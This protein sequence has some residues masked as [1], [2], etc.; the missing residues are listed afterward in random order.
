MGPGIFCLALGGGLLFF[1][2]R[3]PANR[4]RT[5][6]WLSL[7]ALRAGKAGGEIL[8]TPSQVLITETGAE[9]RVSYSIFEA[10]SETDHCFLLFFGNRKSFLPVQKKALA[11]GAAEEFRTFLSEKTG[12]P[13]EFIK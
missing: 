9:T 5:V 1:G 11:P 8:F 13:V 10:V 7:R 2:L 3:F 4:G 12:K 6:G